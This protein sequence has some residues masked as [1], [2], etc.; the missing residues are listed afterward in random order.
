MRLLLIVLSFLFL[1]LGFTASETPDWWVAEDYVKNANLQYKWGIQYIKSLPFKQNDKVLDIGSGDG[2]LTAFIARKVSDGQVIGI[3]KSLSM[4]N[5]A[6]HTFPPNKF[7]N[8]KFQQQSVESMHFNN[9]FN[10]IVSFSSM[11]WVKEMD[12]A[13]ANIAKALKPRGHVFLFFAPD[14]GQDRFDHALNDVMEQHRWKTYF[15]SFQ[16]NFNLISPKQI[17]SLMEANGLF[18]EHIKVITVKEIFKSRAA[19]KKWIA[20]SLPQ[21]HYLPAQ[22]QDRFIDQVIDRYLEKR[23]NLYRQGEITFL[24]YWI[25]VEAKRET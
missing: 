24:D 18:L 2:R 16:S 15:K 12:K 14:Y 8:L 1:N 11:H 7:L 9:E 25:E 20:A 10:W 17:L 22:L 3:D 13:F 23:P 6:K 4:I 19:F 21:V 5:Q